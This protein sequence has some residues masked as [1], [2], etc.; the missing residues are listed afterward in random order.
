MRVHWQAGESVGGSVMLDG[1][2]ASLSC[3]CSATTGW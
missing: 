1:G 2:D 3:V